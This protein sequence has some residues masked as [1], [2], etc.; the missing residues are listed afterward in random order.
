MMHVF[1]NIDLQSV[2]PAE[3]HSAASQ[4]SGQHVRWAHRQNAMFRQ[5]IIKNEIFR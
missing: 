4:S 2:R 1:R 5:R 3:L